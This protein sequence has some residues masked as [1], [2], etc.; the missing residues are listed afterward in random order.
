MATCSG[1]GPS[2]GKQPAQ[3]TACDTKSVASDED[4]TIELK[5]QII[6]LQEAQVKQAI[7]TAMAQNKMDSVEASMQQIL[8]LMKNNMTQSATTLGPLPST[9]NRAT[10]SPFLSVEPGYPCPSP[11]PTSQPPEH[12]Y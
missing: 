4:Q 10:D 8:E 7:A 1:S 6:A 11:T 9:E 12:Y 3:S 2:K 5:A